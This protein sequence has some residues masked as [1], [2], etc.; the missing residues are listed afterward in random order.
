MKKSKI[1]FQTFKILIIIVSIWYIAFKVYSEKQNGLLFYELKN[2]IFIDWVYL[3]T[4]IMLMPVNW[5]LESAKFKLLVRHLQTISLYESI[6]SVLSGITV[7]IFTPKR[8]GDFGG[9]IFILETKNRVSGIFATLLGNLSQ[10]LVTLTVGSALFYIYLPMNAAFKD[11]DI[12]ISIIFLITIVVIAIGLTV[13][14]NISKIGMLLGKL[15]VFKKH[16]DFILFIQKY[17]KSEL[18]NYLS[19]SFLRYVVFTFQFY[20]LLKFF[21]IEISYFKAFIGISQVYFIMALV[22]T[23]ALGELG[24][25]GSIG[26]FILGAFTTLSSGIVAASVLLW[27]INLAVPAVFGTYYLSKLK[28]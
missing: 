17:K 7:S 13:Y 18:L 24:V 22:P 6:K 23:F 10:L 4:A 27:I 3:L 2:Y 8:I 28:Y 14:F 15:P 20:L 26:V 16:T 1:L 5:I 9:R 25:R 11:I 12:N 21:G 19:I